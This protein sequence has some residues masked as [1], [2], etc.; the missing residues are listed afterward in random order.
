MAS[1]GQQWPAVVSSGVSP[2]GVGTFL[3]SCVPSAI[4]VE[5]MAA[6]KPEDRPRI[7]H[8]VDG[9]FAAYIGVYLLSGLPVVL[10]WGGDIPSPVAFSNRSFTGVVINLVLLYGAP[11][12]LALYEE[13][14]SPSALCIHTPTAHTVHAHSLR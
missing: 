11:A 7:K 5:T 13:A 8:A 1:S 12:R 9:A 14:G 10:S 4:L 2:L 3:Y 6:L